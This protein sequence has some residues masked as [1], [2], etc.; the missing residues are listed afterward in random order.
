MTKNWTEST[1]KREL[2]DRMYKREPNIS[3]NNI[4]INTG[5]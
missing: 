5:L 4:K 1:L 2:K 3:G